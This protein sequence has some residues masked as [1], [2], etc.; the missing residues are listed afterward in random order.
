[1]K[2]VFSIKSCLIAFTALVL[3]VQYA[4]AQDTSEVK[5]PVQPEIPDNGFVFRPTLGLGVG[6]FTFFGDIAN[7][8]KG[9]HPNVSRIGYDLRISNP[10]TDY[11]DVSFYT[12][13]GILSSSERTATRNLNFM[14]QIRTGGMVLSY[15]FNQILPE[16]R[17][18]EPYIF[19]G[20]E[21]FEFLSKTDLYDRFGNRYYY[22][23]DGSIRNMDENDPNAANAIYLQRDYKYESDVRELNLDGFGKYPERSW[24]IPVGV[25]FQMHLNE[26]WKFR[27]GTSMHFAFTDLVDGVTPESTGDRAGDSKNDKFLYS[28]FSLNYDLQRLRQKEDETEEPIMPLDELLALLGKD[29]VDSDGDK[30]VDFVDDCA[31]TP[32]GVPVDEKGCPFDKDRDLVFD[33]G[34]D[35]KETPE[36]NVVNTRGVTYTDEDQEKY[37]SYYI[38][39]T[40]ATIVY[41]RVDQEISGNMAGNNGTNGS[42]LNVK[43]NLNYVVII[44][45]EE[46]KIAANE[47]HKFLGFKDFRTVESG[48]TVYYIVGNYKSIDEAIKRKY[49][50]EETGW[51]VSGIGTTTTSYT[52]DKYGNRVEVTG[53]TTV[54]EDKLP[55]D[56]IVDTNLP[57]TGQAVFRVQIGA[58]YKKI[59]PSVF[60]DAKDLVWV[61]GSDGITRYYSGSFTD[62]NAAAEHKINMITKGY[63]GSFIV[64]Y[65]D[66][67]RVPLNTVGATLVN[68]RDKENLDESNDPSKTKID[69][70]L[71]K[72]KVQVGAYRNDVPTEMLDVF[73]KIGNVT[74]YRD[75]TTGITR[76]VTGMYN[77]YEEAAKVLD[78][79]NATGVK[80]AFIIADFN[81][82]IISSKEALELLNQN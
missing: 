36:G 58:F 12:I 3:C 20:V 24:A 33:Y 76:Y 79:I 60:K 21:S 38:D 9:F 64:A 77:S 48:D 6:T 68:P 55:Q 13:F 19:L 43:E 44:G 35:E 2:T 29:T 57:T 16:K 37:F 11:L 50:L 7:N 1:M 18:I 82:R 61:T 34:D 8:N 49:N 41:E 54:P 47:L 71:I 52:T 56:S 30:V 42:G 26:R 53:I 78:Q 65:K 46:K 14:S 22:W 31:W 69:K 15:N 10:L 74:P 45:T 51:N 75:N 63:V 66:Q 67:K 40:G 39:S 4:G 32:A 17:K 27:M 73:L 5:E 25:G 62:M 28:S 81:G 70:S 59:S 80:D 72:F 23:S